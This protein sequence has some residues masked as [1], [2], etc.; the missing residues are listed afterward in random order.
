MRV[1]PKPLAAALLTLCFATF[2]NTPETAGARNSRHHAGAPAQRRTSPHKSPAATSHA[3]HQDKGASHPSHQDKGAS[4]PSHQ[5]KGSPRSD[6]APTPAHGHERTDRV[7]HRETRRHETPAP[8][9]AV[10][11]QTAATIAAVL[12]TPCQNA[13]LDPSEENLPLLR[14]AVLCLV[15]RTRAEHGV[16]PLIDNSQLEAAAEGHC[17][18]LISDD[19]F[20]HV[21]PD[22]ETPVDRIKQTGYIPSPSVGYVIGENLAWGTYS[23]STPQ[24]IV[25]AWIAS[26]GHLAN[27]L[28]ARYTETGIGI[29]PSVPQSLGEGNPGGTYAQEFGVIIH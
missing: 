28:E 17:A 3:P 19:Y 14:A 29:T 9:L 15:N 4:H 22:G 21:A 23:L 2:G 13:E 1:S 25:A 16:L 10:A 18:E 7:P 6:T 24:A 12:A 27:I 5:D 11:D 20:A 26:P 8:E